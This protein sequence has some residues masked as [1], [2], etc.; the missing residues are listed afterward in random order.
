MVDFDSINVEKWPEAANLRG[1]S[2]ILEPGDLLFVPQFWC[3]Q[4]LSRTN[5]AITKFDVRQR[6]HVDAGAGL[7]ISS[8]WAKR[9]QTWC[10]TF[11]QVQL[12]ARRT[13]L[14]QDA[15]KHNLMCVTS[16]RDLREETCAHAGERIRSEACVPL[17]V[18]RLLEER[19]AEAEG[20][21]DVC[22]WL[23]LIGLPHPPIELIRSDD[24]QLHAREV[25]GL[26]LLP[27]MQVGLMTSLVQSQRLLCCQVGTRRTGSSIQ[28]Q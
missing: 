14:R 17:Q 20:V 25:L 4:Y 11:I 18:S 23:S 1:M 3:V 7:R 19:L 22:H 5:A 28:R 9:M 21:Q 8:S 16:F 13:P 2:C 10:S 26:Q 12:R 24:A 15:G 27:S 6:P